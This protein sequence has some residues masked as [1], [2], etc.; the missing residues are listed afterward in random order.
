V[1]AQLL[2]VTLGRNADEPLLQRWHH[3]K[4]GSNAW[5]RVARRGWGPAYEATRFWRQTMTRAV[6]VP[7]ETVPY[8]FRHSSIVRGLR[9][10]LP[11]R[12]VAALHDTSVK[13]IEDHYAAHIVDATEDLARRAILNIGSSEKYFQ[14]A[15]G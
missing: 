15:A 7:V 4:K 10:M 5:Q 6:G 3:A 14:A 8:A 13:M 12:L 1:C 9:A 2:S 11:I